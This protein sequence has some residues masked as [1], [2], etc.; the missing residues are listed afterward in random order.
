MSRAASIAVCAAIAAVL[1]AFFFGTIH[2]GDKYIKKIA[3][4]TKLCD[5]AEC[6][7]GAMVM[8]ERAQERYGIPESLLN[9]CF[10][11]ASIGETHFRR[12]NFLKRPI[13]ET[14]LLPCGSMAGDL[15][16]V[17]KAN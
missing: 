12:G 9:W 8:R 5:D 11:I 3:R 13:M 2:G 17:K 7:F 14:G 10:G 16:G 1:G 6:L 15:F 4:D